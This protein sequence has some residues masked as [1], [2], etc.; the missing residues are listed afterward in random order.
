MHSGYKLNLEW[1]PS[2]YSED[3]DTKGKDDKP[4][5]RAD[6][7]QEAEPVKIRLKGIYKRGAKKH[8]HY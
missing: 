7:G 5:T 1:I 6:A 2:A 3:P 8:G 4:G